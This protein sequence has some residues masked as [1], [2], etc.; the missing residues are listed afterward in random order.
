MKFLPQNKKKTW[1]SIALLIFSVGGI[2][3]TFSLNKQPISVEGPAPVSGGTPPE[4]SPEVLLPFGNKL[5]LRILSDEKF[6]A[7]RSVPSLSVKVE[8]LGKADLFVK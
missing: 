3:L 2:I 4:E 6:R 7:L 1:W 5:D 8:E